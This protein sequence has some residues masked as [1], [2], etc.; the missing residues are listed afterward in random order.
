[1]V[2]SFDYKF[3]KS[4]K[5]IL[6]ILVILL[7]ISIYLFSTNDQ[8]N[9]YYKIVAIIFMVINTL[10]IAISRKR[11]KINKQIL[12]WFLFCIFSLISLQ[13]STVRSVEV[14][15]VLF[16]IGFICFSLFNYM[17]SEND[18]DIVLIGVV[19]AGVLLSFYIIATVGIKSLISAR[20][21][22][23]GYNSND[24]GVK[25]VISSLLSLYF[26][27]K[28]KWK[29]S[30]VLAILILIPIVIF[31]YSKTS[32]T[33]LIVGISMFYIFKSKNS[34]QLTKNFF[35]VILLLSIMVYL[36]FSNEWL[37]NSIGIRFEG[38]INQFLTSSGGYSSDRLRL[39]FIEAGKNLFKIKP[40]L[41]YGIDNF[42]YVSFYY[43]G[44]NEFAH[45]NYI[46]L[47]VNLGIVG[48]FIYYFGYYITIKDMIRVYGK[49]TDT[50]RILFIILI[51]VMIAQIG[52]VSYN[53]I[54]YSVIII[55]C[56][57][58]IKLEVVKKRYK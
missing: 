11:L 16:F 25:L 9:L 29:K 8:Y 22:I 54:L 47:I 4:I 3:N 12:L 5:K 38:L 2:N 50:I 41:G 49:D 43:T 33:M 30:C 37:Y 51:L 45:N 40:L 18:I 36:M 13:W 56:A 39:G 14:I 52:I 44:V 23:Q 7:M 31:T 10:Y 34:W 58:A 28:N 55:L 15:I 19:I 27:Y 46:E 6:D 26:I 53:K 24:V 1:M 20:F 42:R 48:S 35:T 17:N 32:I 21:N 57:S